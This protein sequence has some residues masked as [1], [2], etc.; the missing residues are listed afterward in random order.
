MAHI[1]S[2]GT[3]KGNRDSRSKRLGIKIYGNQKVKSGNIIVRQKGT[4]YHPGM[5]VGMG[6]DYTLFA[7]KAGNVIFSEKF[8]KRKVS[9][10]V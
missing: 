2:G 10:E 8:G 4:Q 1:K 6:K 7:T 3:T 9:V 5:G